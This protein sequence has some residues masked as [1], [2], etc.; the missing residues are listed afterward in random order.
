[1]SKQRGLWI[2][3]RPS[4]DGDYQDLPDEDYNTAPEADWPDDRRVG[5]E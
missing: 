3:V 5:W 2:E 4:V 1:M